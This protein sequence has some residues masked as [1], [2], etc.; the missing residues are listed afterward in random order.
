MQEPID[1]G[2]E[3]EQRRIAIENHLQNIQHMRHNP[4]MHVGDATFGEV[5]AKLLSH[6]LSV[7]FAAWCFYG[8]WLMVKELIRCIKNGIL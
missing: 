2:K 6:L 8:F 5:V 7:V 1:M 4:N 3:K